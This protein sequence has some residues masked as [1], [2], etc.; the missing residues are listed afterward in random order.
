MP[1]A[2]AYLMLFVWPVVA[3]ILFRVL[4]L[5]KAAVWTM[6]G[7]YLLLPAATSVKLPMLPAIDKG[8][9]PSVTALILCMIYGPKADLAPR[10]T[11]R[12][13][14]LA[15]FSL[16]LLMVGV[17]VITVILNPEPVIF[18]PMYIAGLRLY[19][20]FSMIS[21]LI[22]ALIPFWIGMRYL[23]DHAGH[24]LLLQAFVF[25]ALAYSIP[26]LVE[27]R[28]SPQLHTWIYGFFQHDFTQHI[29][30][31]GFRP[32][33][34]LNHGLMVGIFLCM[35]VVAAL[36]LW[37][38]ELRE[39]KA[40]SA[41]IYAAIWLLIVLVVSKNL[42]ALAIAALLAVVVVFTGRRLQ[43]TFAIV[44][45]AVILLYPVLRG[46]GH[47]PVEAVYDMALSIDAERAE[48]LRFRLINEDL[49]LARANEKPAFGW[50]SWGRNLIYSEENGRVSTIADGAWIIIIGTY[51]WLGY[52]AHF[53]LLTLPILLYTLKRSQFGPSLVT[54]GLLLM[55][56]A[57]LIDLIPNAGLVAYVWLLAGGLAGYV[58]WRPA[59]NTGTA[60][61]PQ[62]QDSPV[63][64][65]R[66]APQ[67]ASWVLSNTG[68]SQR[69][70]RTER[71]RGLK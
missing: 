33:V 70:P 8:M 34:F 18:G 45:A 11:G 29:R 52:I 49:L 48:S 54:P 3:I 5:Q 67:P 28:L 58:V 43:T 55:L 38:D 15:V 9:V 23:N 2:V 7:G 65:G 51:G 71:Q 35:A 42:G 14:R 37:R 31:G 4:P 19:D 20:A 10:M 39:G 12:F 44:I 46:A 24:R 66:A 21:V 63:R 61:S 47:I 57:T 25:G 56:C 41:W 40:T 50:G 13:G 17:P 62:V 36:A 27:V 30:A 1:N 32:V 16:V 26:A 59:E 68:P 60:A 69:R 22:V 53:G 64:W 6:L